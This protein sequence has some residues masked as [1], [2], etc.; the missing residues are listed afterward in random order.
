MGTVTH[1][2]GARPALSFLLSPVEEQRAALWQSFMSAFEHL[3]L[4]Y[5]ESQHT[6]AHSAHYLH[7]DFKLD[8]D[9][10]QSIGPSMKYLL[11]V[12]QVV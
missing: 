7:C 9:L 12:P 8:L 1:P 5:F 6:E 4:A 10:K 11:T 2:A 3:A